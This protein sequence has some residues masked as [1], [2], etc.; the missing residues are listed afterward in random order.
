MD[1]AFEVVARLR[2]SRGNRPACAPCRVWRS[3]II[4]PG[5]SNDGAENDLLS[6]GK[7]SQ[8]DYFVG[9]PSSDYEGGRR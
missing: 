9:V 2:G 8:R 6:M 3:G 7:Y 5:R 1:E 4:G